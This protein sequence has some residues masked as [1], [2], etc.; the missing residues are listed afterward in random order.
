MMEISVDGF[1]DTP[2]LR[3]NGQPYLGRFSCSSVQWT[4]AGSDVL[5]TF[6]MTAREI[7]DAAENRLIWTDQGVQR[8]IKPGLQ[9]A[10]P[11]EL[12]LTDGY[13]DSSMYIFD[14]DNADDIVEKLLWGRRL[15]L[16][17]LVWNLRPGTF[18]AYWDNDTSSIWVYS[19]KVYLP[20]SHHRQQAILKA[21]RTYDE[22]PD[23]Y[24]DFSPDQQFK[25]EL[26]FLTREDEG[27]YF[28]DKNQRPRPTAKSKAYDLTTEDDLSVLAKRVIDKSD[29]LR[30]NVNRVTDR[31]TRTNPQVV[32][33]ST[34][35]QMMKIVTPSAQLDETEIEG[36]AEIAASFY[37]A[38]SEVRSELGRVTV[39]ERK[40]IRETSLVDSAV[41]M[42]GYAHLMRD[43]RSELPS[44]GFARTLSKW[45]KDLEKLAIQQ[46]YGKWSGDIF[47]RD[48]PLW[49]AVGV[50]K[51]RA[52][53]DRL[54]TSNTGATRG[55]CGRVLRQFLAIREE[56]VD[57]TFL[58]KK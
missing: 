7:A 1:E 17:P 38:L 23:A 2:K 32:T 3:A 34:L 15:F 28:F 24:P 26:Y 37:D 47:A 20:D 12:P 19:G 39:N 25:V 51:P 43:F 48:N 14:S 16:N 18:S 27:N 10:P 6:T 35:R 44:L 9:A 13:P 46:S 40:T 56:A 55:E 33:L 45:R 41:M 49:Q 50:L 29:A 53:S 8:G 52:G 30:G 31:L 4:I 57:L 11:R 22:E 36:V 42:F 54:T 58:A 5:A 21:V